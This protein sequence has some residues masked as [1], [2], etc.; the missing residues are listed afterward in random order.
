MVQITRKSP[1]YWQDKNNRIRETI[2]LVEKSSKPIKTITK[3][4]FVRN[5]QF[6]LTTYTGGVKGA[7]HEAG[8]DIQP[9]Q[10]RKK[11]YF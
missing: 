4:D 9:V 8:Y 5:G 3:A 6:V 7:L 2:R 11:G 1:G 10:R